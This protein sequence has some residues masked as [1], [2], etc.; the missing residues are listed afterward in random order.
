MALHAPVPARPAPPEST[1]TSWGRMAALGWQALVLA[2][3]LGL[4]AWLAHNTHAQ[5]QARGIPGGFDFLAQAAGFDIGEQP[6][7]FDADQPYWRAFAVGLLNTLRVMLLGMLGCTVLGSLIGLARHAG[8]VWLQGLARCYVETLRNTPLLVQLLMGYGL[9]LGALPSTPQV[10]PGWGGLVLSKAGLSLPWPEGTGLGAWTWHQPQLDGLQ[11]Q[12]GALLS[13]EFLALLIGLTLYTSAYVAEVVRS[14][15][16]SV[17]AGQ[18]EAAQALGL[19]AHEVLWRVVWP[20]AWRV[21][22]P[23]FTNQY[24]NL[25]KNSSLAVAVGYPD[26]VSIASTSLNQTGRAVECMSLVMAIYLGLSLLISLLMA[27]LRPAGVSGAVQAASS[28]RPPSPPPSD[29]ASPGRAA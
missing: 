17:P 16:A 21:M 5:M 23:G 18:V 29:R 13:C 27:R 11:V 9:L 24:L 14:G 3:L 6:L 8:S 20:Q 4:L 2:L 15:L 1:W 19:R 7:A 25:C 10:L 22:A 12:G 26:L 28:A